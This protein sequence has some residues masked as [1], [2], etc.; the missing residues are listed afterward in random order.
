[1]DKTLRAEMIASLITINCERHIAGA[2]DRETW[3]AKQNNLWALAA[4]GL[5]AS[6]VMRLVCPSLNAPVP[7]YAVR[8]QLRDATLAVGR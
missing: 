7:P 2:I 3:T 5:V 4:A 1:M 8:K 6:E